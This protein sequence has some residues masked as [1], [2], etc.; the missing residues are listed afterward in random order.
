MSQLPCKTYAFEQHAQ[1][2]VFLFVLFASVL[3]VAGVAF[4]YWIVLPKAIQFLTNFDQPQ[5]NIQIRAKD[6][7]SFF[8][9]T[10]GVMGLIFQ[11]PIG[12]LA[13]TR[14]GIVTPKQLAQNRRYAYLVIAIV[15]MLL[16]GTDPIS[17]L[18][19]M[20]PLLLLFE[21]SLVLARVFGTP[22]R[23]DSETEL[24]TADST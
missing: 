3:L 22:A 10:V 1:R 16:P 8:T 2:L 24:A 21:A 6:Y 17:M 7:Y 20:V 19:E 12:I 18:L 5:F 14:L 23:A 15:A 11:L 13:V 4:G 9:M